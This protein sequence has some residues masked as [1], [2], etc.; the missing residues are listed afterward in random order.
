MDLNELLVKCSD[1]ILKESLELMSRANLKHYEYGGPEQTRKKISKLLEL[2]HQ[3]VD[4][5][6]LIPMINYIEKTAKKR[7]MSGFELQEVQTAFN[8][9]EECIWKQILKVI[10]AS[11]QGDALALVS[12]ILGSGKD[13]LA[14]TYVSLASEK[15]AEL[16]EPA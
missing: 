3:S 5:K 7:F 15:P 12:S 11:G 13:T 16:V 14:R 2:T 1:T 9:L 10:P 4:D 8:V 6:N